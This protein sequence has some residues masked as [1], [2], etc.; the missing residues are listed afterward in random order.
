MRVA[1]Q[2]SAAYEHVVLAKELGEVRLDQ[3]N[4]LVP[5]YVPRRVGDVTAPGMHVDAVSG[6]NRATGWVQSQRQA[7]AAA[8]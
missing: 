6:S 1:R 8:H 7:D 4:E 2:R 3:A 5:P